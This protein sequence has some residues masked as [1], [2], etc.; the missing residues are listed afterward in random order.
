MPPQRADTACSLFAKSERLLFTICRKRTKPASRVFTFYKKCTTSTKHF[1]PSQF[2]ARDSPEN[3][4]RNIQSSKFPISNPTNHTG[5]ERQ[6][7]YKK[8]AKTKPTRQDSADT[9]HARPRPY[10]TGPRL[11]HTVGRGNKSLGA[12][13]A[14]AHRARAP[15]PITRGSNSSIR[16][17]AP[18]A[19]ARRACYK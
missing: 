15:A 7:K 2:H 9:E 13:A 16:T 17:V 8:G 4:S 12:S 3:Y 6:E 14:H 10:N 19:L 18:L 1:Y 5:F 11:G